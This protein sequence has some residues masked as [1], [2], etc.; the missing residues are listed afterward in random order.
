MPREMTAR[1][2]EILRF[3]VQFQQEHDYTPSF[4]E[5]A[6]EFQ[7]RSTKAIS[8][9]LQA[10]EV[11]GYLTRERK[12]SR[13]IRLEPVSFELYGTGAASSPAASAPPLG[14]LK[15]SG[16]ST[17]KP[18]ARVVSI[19][20]PVPLIEGAAIAANPAGA[21]AFEDYPIS[22]L[23]IDSA[24][25]GGGECFAIQVSGDSMEGAHICDGDLAIIRTQPEVRDGEI[26]AVDLEGE[27]TLK[28][29]RRQGKNVTLISANPRYAPRVVDLSHETVR[30]LGKFVGIVRQA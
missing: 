27:V 14:S 18:V 25:F 23:P 4:R 10:L 19:G 12:K 7:I 24:L 30:I 21:T 8:D 28:Y 5:I 17:L 22:D 3:I 20:S 16:T 29:F 9:H 15:R 26:A 6:Q 2:A 11:R 1:Q 13:T